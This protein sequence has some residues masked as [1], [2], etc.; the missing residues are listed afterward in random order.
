M[1]WKRSLL[2]LMLFL[3][4]VCA[5]RAQIGVLPQKDTTLSETTD[6]KF[7]VGDEWEYQTRTG[8]EKSTLIILKVES[9]PE[10][11]VIVHV[12]VNAIRLANCHGGPEPDSVPHMPFARRALNDSVTKKIASKRPLPDYE[13]GYEEWKKAYSKKRAGIYVI[14]VSTAVSVAEKMFHWGK[15]VEQ[16]KAKME[17]AKSRYG[18]Q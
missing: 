12:A 14:A 13:D 18:L 3:A 16:M 10:L 7:K 17:A 15:R 11:G 2:W 6:E 8:E 9:S 5:V 4:S 1:K